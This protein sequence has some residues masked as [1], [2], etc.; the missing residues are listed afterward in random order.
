M[1]K[2]NDNEAGA[3]LF[4]KGETTLTDTIRSVSQDP[5]VPGVWRVMFDDS[6]AVVI[7]MGGYLNPWGTLR[8]YNDF[9][10]GYV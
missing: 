2:Y 3:R 7:Y 4:I 1:K 8:K 10:E 5:A 9:E 6:Y